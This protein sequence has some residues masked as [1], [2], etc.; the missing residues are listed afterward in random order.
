MIKKLKTAAF[1]ILPI[2]AFVLLIHFF[3]GKIS[4]NI[5]VTFLIGA[6]V[7]ILGQA[8]FMV[9][10][11][12]SIEP[13]G[14]FVGGSVSTNKRF[15]IF[16]IF[17]LVF[18]VFST[19]AEPDMQVFATKVASGGFGFGK[20]LFLIVAGVG[21]GSF[22]SLA[23]TRIVTRF[24]L[25][26]LL[27]I[28]YAVIIVLAGFS[29]ESGFAMSLDA[30]ANT[31]GVV[32][33]PFLLALG[34]GV[35]R[36]VSSNK[37]SSEDSF[38]LIALSSAGPIIAVLV[39][40]LIVNGTADASV[41]AVSNVASESLNVGELALST[42][43]DVAFSIIPLVVVFFV[44]E[45]LFIKISRQ[46]KKK[47][48]LG[49]LITF[50]GFYLF[51]FGIELGLTGMGEAVGKVLK[52]S[53]NM[54]LISVITALLGFFVVFS[55]PSIRVLSRQIED[56]TNRNIKSSVVLISTA[57]A[58]MLASVLVVLRL[59]YDI[60]IWWYVGVIYGLSFILALFVPKLFTAIAFDSG[61]VATGTLTVA[62]IFP[63]ISGVAGGG[64]DGY[65]SIAILTMVPI[66]VMEVLGLVY[67]VQVQVDK[68]VARKILVS[69]SKT[70]DKFSNIKKL[71]AKHE[72]AFSKF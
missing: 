54:V 50:I 63:I 40:N 21:V 35:A 7:L 68:R 27:F 10:I 41:L 4:T 58:I 61:G 16:I 1:S 29:S 37:S 72:N 6:V 28:S 62:F 22:I 5:L 42:L 66:L 14:G 34:V 49:S 17:G 33:S 64:L 45:A 48:L 11:E 59:F 26:I 55:E 52:D 30:G 15:Y 12:N 18:G 2:I 67:V 53:G 56:V 51:L 8:V 39:L 25:N 3:V 57:V 60:S 69:L 36:L 70:E 32:T 23:L 20:F 44:F 38:G 43:I 65:G 47:L 9:G 19:I 24:N 31:T 13:M 46:E 71:K